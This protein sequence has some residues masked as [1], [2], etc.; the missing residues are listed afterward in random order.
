M[1]FV[2]PDCRTELSSTFYCARCGHQF[3]VED[4]IPVLF[5]REQRF[6][7]AS[8]IR[9]AY[10]QIY[11]ENAEVWRD[12]GRTPEFIEYFAGLLKSMSTGQ[13]LEI[14]CGEGFLL[15]A[16]SASEKA[17]IDIS[18]EALRKARTHSAAHFAAALAE[19]LPFPEE[20]FDL[21]LSVGV[22]EHFIDDLAA[23]E[24]IR[25]VLRPGGHYVMLIH[26][27]LS[28]AA[29]LRLKL[30]EYVFPNFRP[31]AFARWLYKKATRKVIQPIQR[32]YTAAGVQAV[33][34]QAGLSVLNVISR[35]SHGLK[36]LSGPHVYV[37]VT[38]KAGSGSEARTAGLHETVHK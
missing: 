6:R 28:S 14:G 30:S 35:N 17:A 36:A 26:V 21:V 3:P 29:R 22:M 34:E 20:S 13:V 19:R 12:Q 23:N 18:S 9:G 25:R 16:I 37:F 33:L 27:D 32:R 15:S 10:D 1:R 24:E 7:S 31:A 2:C 38:R 8:D 4:G 5:T 11:E